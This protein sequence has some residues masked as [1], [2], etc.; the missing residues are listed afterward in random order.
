MSRRSLWSTWFKS[1]SL[2]GGLYRSDNVRLGSFEPLGGVG[3]W[4]DCP[5]IRVAHGDAEQVSGERAGPG[6]GGGGLPHLGGGRGGGGGGAGG[7]AGQSSGQCCLLAQVRE[8]EEGCLG[9]GRTT[10]HGRI[11]FSDG[12][13]SSPS[14]SPRSLAILILQKCSFCSSI[15][16]FV[17]SKNQQCTKHHHSCK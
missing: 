4:D 2:K 3:R 16:N 7:G 11:N 6:G 8:E 9:S 15:I 13:L 14:S 5:R 17:H 1:K 10:F 12:F